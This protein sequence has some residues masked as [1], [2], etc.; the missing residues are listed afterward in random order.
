MTNSKLSAALPPNNAGQ[1]LIRKPFMHALI[2]SVNGAVVV[3]PSFAHS[4]IKMDK[5]KSYK[6]G[7]FIYS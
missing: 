6:Q 5:K 3:E 1:D 7:H 4:K 2:V